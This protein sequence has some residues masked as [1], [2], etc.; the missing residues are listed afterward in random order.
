MTV[1]ITT[2]I[3]PDDDLYPV[4]WRTKV[5]PVTTTLNPDD[6]LYNATWAG[7]SHA[8]QTTTIDQETTTLNPD[9]ELYNATWA[10]GHQTMTINPDDDLYPVKWKQPQGPITTTMTT[11]LEP[12]DDLYPVTWK[13]GPAPT[14]I[15]SGTSVSG[16]SQHKQ[17]QVVDAKATGTFNDRSGC[18]GIVTRFVLQ[19]FG[20]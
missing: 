7:E 12:D 20:L 3:K 11:T 17:Q 16:G 2:T 4:R 13:V 19:L 14:G 5:E 10:T 9:D 15:A 18:V 1:T 6:D 8:P